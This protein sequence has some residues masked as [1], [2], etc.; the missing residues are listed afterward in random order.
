M[1]DA[2]LPADQPAEIPPPASAELEVILEVDV[3]M[4]APGAADAASPQADVDIETE[5]T[6]TARQRIL[7]HLEDTE[8][9][10][11]VT[12]ICT[13]TGLDRSVVDPVL[14]R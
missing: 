11:H 6:R 3:N 14:S 13:G 4:R 7:D 9:P 2:A 8:G 12:A 5:D 10:R 1:T